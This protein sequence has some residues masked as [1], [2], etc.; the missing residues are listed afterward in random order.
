MYYK[1][2]F[3]SCFSTSLSSDGWMDS[4]EWVSWC[5]CIW[6]DWNNEVFVAYLIIY[7]FIKTFL[8]SIVKGFDNC[9]LNPYVQEWFVCSLFDIFTLCILPLITTKIQIW[10]VV[11]KSSFDLCEL[12]LDWS[13]YG[14]I[15]GAVYLRPLNS[16]KSKLI[17]PKSLFP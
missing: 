8:F 5:V 11:N 4:N 2:V 17:Y 12:S 7:M 15:I 14:L 6:L 1:C 9:V 10:L 3:F 16:T 13:Y